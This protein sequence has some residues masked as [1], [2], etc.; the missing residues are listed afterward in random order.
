MSHF[1]DNP[2]YHA[3]NTAQQVMSEGNDRVKYYIPTIAAFAGLKEHT[4]DNFDV[5]D[6]I[7]PEESVFVIFSKNELPLGKQWQILTHIDMYQLVYESKE[8]PVIAEQKWVDLHTEN[9]G[10]MKAL[11]EL[12]K[13]GPFLDR[14]IEFGDYIGVF[15]A[16]Q[17]VAMA[18]HRFNP[19]PYREISAVCTHPDYVGK[20]YGYVML[21]EQ[22]KRILERDE[23]PFLHVRNDN[24]G[25]IRLY[26]KLGFVIRTAMTA[27]VIKKN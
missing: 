26:E 8:I 18:G 16:D 15:D 25:A 7:S 24:D 27:Y 20:G 12:T 11:V 1:L 6:E 23:I 10:A 13:P 14:T 22:V 17:L 21:Q 9:V 4:E 2:I 19:A 3:L 5:L